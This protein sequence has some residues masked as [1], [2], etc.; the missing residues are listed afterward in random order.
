M[1]SLSGGLSVTAS[2]SIS[3]IAGATVADATVLRTTG[4]GA[5]I[6]LSYARNLLNGPVSVS[7]TGTD[8][9]VLIRTAKPLV[10]VSS[11][12]GGALSIST[13]GALAISDP[14]NR[15]ASFGSVSATSLV[16]N[17][18]FDVT[19]TAAW[20][21][22]GAVTIAAGTHAVTLGAGNGF[23]T[24]QITG[25]A[26][27]LTETGPIT[28]AQANVGSLALSSTGAMA[29]ITDSG[30][31]NVTGAASFTS[32]GA[33][34]LDHLFNTF[35]GSVSVNTPL[36]AL[37]VNNTDTALATSVVGGLFNVRSTGSVTQT[38]SITTGTLAANAPRG[39]TLTA[40]G[41]QI[42]AL[43]AIASQSNIAIA[44]DGPGLTV[45]QTVS[46][47]DLSLSTDGNFSLAAQGLILGHYISIA[48]LN[49]GE[50]SNQSGYGGINLQPG[51]HYEIYSTHAGSAF[52]GTLSAGDSVGHETQPPFNTSGTSV[53]LFVSP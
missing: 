26:V 7:T 50:F 8:G 10:L 28:I 18:A 14:A 39:I 23:G 15:I 16:L 2:G 36:N 30:P 46:G 33:I 35:R 17:A 51:G 19:Q 27:T 21:I 47:Y 22:P 44:N 24:V 34:T 29:A 25:G 40:S 32:T 37:L 41:N 12:V 48:A 45:T 5:S 13:L 38:G 49:G 4:S 52:Q 11:T 6:S 43:G 20:Q 9:N 42:G 1:V 53:F 31:L 3:Q